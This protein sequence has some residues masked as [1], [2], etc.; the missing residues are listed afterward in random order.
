MKLKLS[1]ALALLALTSLGTGTVLAQGFSLP[2]LLVESKAFPD[3]GV[4]PAKYSMA[5]GNMQPDFRIT[6]AP[7]GT[8]SYAVIFHDIDVA[9]QGGTDDVLHWVA[10]NIPATAGATQIARGQA[11]RGL[12]GRQEHHRPEHVHGLGRAV[13]SAHAPL[14]VRVL[15]AEREARPSRHR[16]PSG[17]A[18]RDEGQDR[19]KGC[20]CRPLRRAAPA[21]GAAGAPR[22]GAPPAAPAAPAR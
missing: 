14:C 21:A 2:P 7:A 16:E 20:V 13:R 10:W 8:V 18:G 17:T 12:G 19:G 11:A 5:G 3:G 4:V 6:N 22:P 9:L 1:A 15:R